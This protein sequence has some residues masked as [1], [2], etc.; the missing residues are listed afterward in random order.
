[1]QKPALKNRRFG[2]CSDANG[3]NTL[4]GLD[5]LCKKYVTA[6]SVVVEL[7]CYMGV[8]TS[9]FS[10]YAKIV[11]TVDNKV[12]PHLLDDLNNVFHHQGDFQQILP[13]I[14][15][16][17]STVDM[18]YIDGEHDYQ[19]ACR[20]IESALPLINKN[21]FIAGHDYYK[22]FAHNQMNRSTKGYG[23][24]NSQ[25]IEAVRDTLKVE[26]EVFSDSSWLIKLEELA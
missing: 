20:D 15:L 8:S 6:E 1:M 2:L 17:H 12:K 21:G 23:D 24:P 14:R 22:S 5:D 26:P 13:K 9:L 16:L 18:A 11:H 3:I 4:V 19:S 25:V 7:G 10:Y